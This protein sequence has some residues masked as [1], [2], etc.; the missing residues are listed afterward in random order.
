S[1]GQ[2]RA[3]PMDPSASRSTQPAAA[4]TRLRSGSGLL[5]GKFLPPHLGHCY[6]ADFA[7]NFVDRLTILVCSIAA[8]PIPG[9]LRYQWMRELFAADCDVVHVTEELP[10]EPA[11]HPDFWPI[12]TR[13][14]R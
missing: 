7:R 14:L 13:A 9:R 1:P 11:D 5:L 3:L 12:W 2:V 4:Q 6:L 10:Q 8:E